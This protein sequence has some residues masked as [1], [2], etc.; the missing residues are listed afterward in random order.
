MLIKFTVENYRSFK[1]EQI[2]T[3]RARKHS[4]LNE[5]LINGLENRFLKCGVLYG[6]NAS[7][8]TNFIKATNFAKNIVINGVIPGKIINRYFRIDK[9]MYEIPGKFEFEIENNGCDYIYGF[10]I[11]YLHN[12]ICEE[13]LYQI[14]KNKKICIFYR[15]NEN[16]IRTQLRFSS[17]KIQQRFYIYAEDVDE[18][19]TLLAE[20]ASHKLQGIEEFKPFFDVYSWFQKLIIIF[21]ESIYGDY[22][23]FFLNDNKSTFAR[24]LSYFDTGVDRIIGDEKTVDEVLSF[25]PEKVRNDI[26]SNLCSGFNEKDSEYEVSVDLSINNKRISIS[27]DATGKFIAQQLMMDHGN[28]SDLFDLEDESDGTRRLFDLIPIYSKLY[29]DR[30]VFIDE[31]DRSFHSKLTEEFINKFCENSKNNKSQLIFTTHDINLLNLTKF[32][33]DEIW[34]V[35]RVEDKS[36]KLYSLKD[37]KERFDKDVQKEY[38]LGKYGAV[39]HFC[40]Y[41]IMDV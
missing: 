10:K 14:E 37:F 39:P 1:E 20:F 32:R 6:A 27:R 31:L 4:R 34:F 38:M 8:K 40:K 12:R 24:L 22:K 2:F 13:W 3:M 21:P 30:V 26:I 7:G 19:T 23:Q 16:E 9:S 25:L 18:S 5:H 35:E 29:E 28:N 33:Q 15:K 36:S 11:S 41:K 17:K